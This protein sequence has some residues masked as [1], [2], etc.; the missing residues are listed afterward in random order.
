LVRTAADPEQ[1][2]HLW[3]LLAV[4]LKSG[5]TTFGGGDPTMAVLQRELAERRGWLSKEQF[6][7]AYSLARIT[8]GTNILAFCAGT[9]Y[10]LHG[11]LAAFL[12][13]L[14]ASAPAGVLIVWLTIAFEASDRLL[15]TKAAVGAVLAAV[16]GMMCS[17]AWLLARPGFTHA[18]WPRV[19]VLAGGTILLR[20]WL[21]L[22]P[23]QI[24]LIAGIAGWVW[25]EED[26][27]E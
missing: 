18:K 26:I 14:A 7:I 25:K 15:I 2:R 17:S 23:V 12:S 21:Q 16:T 27:P 10:L 5:N 1:K 4:Y 20:E 19:L 13:V 3:P 11:W 9:A 22:T 6:G 8:P 24:I